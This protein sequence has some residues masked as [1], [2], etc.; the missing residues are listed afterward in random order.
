MEAENTQMNA[1]KSKLNFSAFRKTIRES[2]HTPLS[3]RSY[4]QWS[5]M[6]N[7]VSSSLDMDEILAIMREGDLDSLRSLSRYYYRTNSLYRNNIDF[8]ANL[9]LH[10]KPACPC[11]GLNL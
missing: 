4:N 1:E 11:A 3:S 7:P 10:S 5:T 6:S 8:L 9:S 2:S